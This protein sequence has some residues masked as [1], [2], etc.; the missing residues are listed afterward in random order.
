M[1]TP[2][3]KEALLSIQKLG[4]EDLLA[5]AEWFRGKGRSHLYA[6]D[7]SDEII[8]V[9]RVEVDKDGEGSMSSG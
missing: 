1:I 5:V 2:E 4:N 8:G 7:A 3:L 9:F 6:R